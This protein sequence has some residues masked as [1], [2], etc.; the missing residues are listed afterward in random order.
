MVD[1]FFFYVV[2]WARGDLH[3]SWQ[4]FFKVLELISTQLE[5]LRCSLRFIVKS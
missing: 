2:L 4:L 3:C 1:M 5:P